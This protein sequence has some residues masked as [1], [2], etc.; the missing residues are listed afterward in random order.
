MTLTFQTTLD[1]AIHKVSPPSQFLKLLESSVDTLIERLALSRSHYLSEVA[2]L[3]SVG[4]QVVVVQAA[5]RAWAMGLKVDPPAEVPQGYRP[6]SRWS[7]GYW[8]PD[9]RNAVGKQNAKR[10]A[11]LRPTSVPLELAKLGFDLT[12]HGD[13]GRSAGVQ[14]YADLS[15]RVVLLELPHGRPTPPCQPLSYEEFY[16]QL[17]AAQQLERED[18]LK[19]ETPL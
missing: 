19:L 3:E 13:P 1:P 7:A 12:G 14:L 18:A 10:L 6:H 11:A 9:R 4:V 5:G 16:T 2:A 15:R 17:G 8:V